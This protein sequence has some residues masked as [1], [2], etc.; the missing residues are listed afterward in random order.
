MS[1]RGRNSRS[2]TD[3]KDPQNK[4]TSLHAG[5]QDKDAYYEGVS[6]QKEEGD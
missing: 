5:S 1:V 6:I 2:G 4:K 3:K